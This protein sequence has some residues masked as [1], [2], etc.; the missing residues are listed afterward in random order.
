MIGF[1]LG[2]QLP[3]ITKIQIKP[4]KTS[5][6]LLADKEEIGSTGATGMDSTFFENS[7]AELLAKTGNG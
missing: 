5:I 3:A 4:K 7:L 6:L 1:V 2:H